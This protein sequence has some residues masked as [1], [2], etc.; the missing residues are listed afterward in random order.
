MSSVKTVAIGIIVLSLTAAIGFSAWKK[1]TAPTVSTDVVGSNKT[2]INGIITSEKESFFKDARV[3][4]IFAEN[5]LEVN[6]E[7]WAS[8]KIAQ[9]KDKSDFGKY[10]DFVFPPGVQ[11]SDKVKQ[12]FKGVQAYNIF[13]SP[14]VVAS[15]TPIVSILK[16]NDLLVDKKEYKALD[17]EKFLSLMSNKV[18]W[19]TLKNSEEYPVNKTVLIYTSDARYSNSSKMFMGLASYIYNGNDVVVSNEQVENVLPKL[20]ELMESQGHRE[21]S[22]TNLFADYNSIGIGKTPLIFIYESE[23]VEYAIKN[24]G[25]AKDM[26]L[27]YPSP[28]LFTKH[29][30][31]GFNDKSMKLVDILTKND[32][33]K[34]V[35]AE[36]GFRFSGNNHLVE[37][38]KSVGVKVPATIVDVVDPPSFDVLESI[39]TNVEVK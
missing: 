38:A 35:A 11:T 9:T 28:T 39:V 14:M 16:A 12:T 30:M 6:V 34:E 1:S 5:G 7:R 32:Q 33:I 17:M 27:V 15:W 25:V 36:Y 8:G 2:V 37:K 13:Y 26:E 20:K 22:S 4:K 21:S 18:K 23:F 19:K 24:K 29:V 31:V 10:S 3:Q